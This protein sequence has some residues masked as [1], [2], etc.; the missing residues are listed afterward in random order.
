LTLRNTQSGETYVSDEFARDKLDDVVN[1]AMLGLIRIADPY[2]LASYS[3][4]KE[5]KTGSFDRTKRWTRY[6]LNHDN[7]RA[8]ARA[9]NLLGNVASYRGDFQE[10]YPAIHAS[11]GS[12][13]FICGGAF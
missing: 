6:A 2:L 12:A 9:Y 5:Q 8:A 11:F 4:S 10:A 1:D 7:N 13:C 3:F